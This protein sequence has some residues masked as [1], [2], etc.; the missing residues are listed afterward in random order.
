MIIKICFVKNIIIVFEQEAIKIRYNG[1][2]ENRIRPVA[3]N[4]ND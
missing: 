4:S 2:E 3:K 1:I